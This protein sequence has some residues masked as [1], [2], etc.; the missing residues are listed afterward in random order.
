MTFFK[1]EALIY[2]SIKKYNTSIKI[3]WHTLWTNYTLNRRNKEIQSSM[4]LG[5]TFGTKKSWSFKTGDLLKEV[6]FI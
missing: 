3:S 4:Y 2:R 6:Q 1:L 5:V